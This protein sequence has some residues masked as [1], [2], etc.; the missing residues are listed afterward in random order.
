MNII[1]TGSLGNIGK[2]LAPA[3]FSGGHAVTI[4]SSN[5]GRQTEIE[6]MGAK[7]AIGTMQDAGFLT[8]TFSGA[9]VVYLMETM[10]AAGNVFDKS[11]DFI[12]EITQIGRNYKQAVERSGRS[13]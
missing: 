3:L 4:I 2:L 6:A 10:E 11:V 5:P 13:F 9:D 1:L 7:A 8:K 12:E